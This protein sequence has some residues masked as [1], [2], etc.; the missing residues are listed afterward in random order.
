MI[1]DRD[2]GI[3]LP[4]GTRLSAAVW[5]PDDAHDNPVPAILEYLPYR[6]TDGTLERDHGMHPHF[7]RNGY[8]AIRVDRRGC[9]DSEGLFDDEYSEDEL[10]DGEDIIAWIAAQPWCTGSVGM[11]GISWGGFN[12]LQIA[13]RRPDALKAVI[14]IGTTV[15]RFHDD[16]HYKGGIQLSENVGWAATVL[17]WFSMPP[18]PKIRPDWTAMWLDRMEHTPFV[19]ER[20]TRASDR[21]E[22]WKHGSICEDYSAI[23]A[24]VLVMG[25]LHDGYRNAMA[26][27]AD[28]AVG[29]VKPS[30][31]LGATSTPILRRSGRAWIILIWPLNGGES[32]SRARTQMSK[33][34]PTTPPM[35]WTAARQ[36][37]P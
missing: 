21:D 23:Q 36:I 26:A 1:F 11:Q 8:A 7:A 32:G 12:G 2:L 31:G 27:M 13:A 24:P 20:W 37:Q 29:P 3:S 15:D 6:K 5:L 10:K 30:W 17:S 4:D 33:I 18:D 35:S 25:G 22:Y 34:C 14:S 19:A 16:I 9:G 28:Y